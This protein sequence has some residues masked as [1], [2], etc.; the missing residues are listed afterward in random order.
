VCIIDRRQFIGTG[1][2]TVYALL[3]SPLARAD[4]IEGGCTLALNR[5]LPGTSNGI[6]VVGKDI[7]LGTGDRAKD[8][9][10][11]RALARLAQ[12]LGERP[13]FAFYEDGERA[14][15]YASPGEDGVPSTWG[16]VRFG[17]RLFGDLT[18]KFGDDGIAILGVL[19]HEFAHI[20]QYRRRVM[21]ALAGSTVKRSE[22]HAD[23]VSGYYLGLR[24]LAN[25]SLK[26]RAA[27]MALYSIGDYAYNDPQHHGTPEE[28]VEA[29][30]YGFALA[31]Q[32]RDYLD[33][34]NHGLDWV[35]DRY[36]A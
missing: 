25:S 17:R 31:N 5:G 20:A 33:A 10:L 2:A 18:N 29:S 34:F 23:L 7:D 11:G 15:A 22:L 12:T 16:K 26:L 35:M 8:K 14:N 1:A 3:Q 24:K 27:G 19:A 36:K 4:E 28:R 32:G 30:E 6:G 13:T 21:S 9:L